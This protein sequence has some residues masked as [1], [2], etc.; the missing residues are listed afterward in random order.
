MVTRNRTNR[1]DRTVS[2]GVYDPAFILQIKTLRS[3]PPVE[4]S[5]L[6]RVLDFVEETLKVHWQD[7]QGFQTLQER[8]CM[9]RM[10][11]EDTEETDA[12]KEITLGWLCRITFCLQHSQGSH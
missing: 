5:E 1:A 6:E 11:L 9:L 8:V 10:M 12:G 3:I 2:N 4:K 7:H